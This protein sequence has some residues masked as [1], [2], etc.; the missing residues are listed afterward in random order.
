M[1]EGAQCEDNVRTPQEVNVFPRRLLT[2]EIY[3]EKK[4][5]LR[6]EESLNR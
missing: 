3:S 5:I 4:K 1:R 2:G 6:E